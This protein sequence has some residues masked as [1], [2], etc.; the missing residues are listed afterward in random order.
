MKIFN[1]MTRKTEEFVPI[2][3]GK[4]G[5][6]VCGPTV[7]N[8][9]HIGNARP[10]CVFDTMRRY[11]MYRGYEVKYVQNFTDVDDKIIKKANEEGVES[12]EISERYI[13][14]FKT[15]TQGLNVL[16]PDISP[17]VTENMGIIIKIIKDLVDRG[18]AYQSG[19]DVYFETSKFADYGKLSHQ[20]LDELMAGAR[21]NVNEQKKSPMDFAV[22]KGAKE[23]EP[24]WN[25]PWGKGRPG[26]H[27]ECSAMSKNYIGNTLD[28]HGGGQDLIFPHHEN[29]IAQSECAT[30]EILANYWLHNGH[31]NVDNKKMSKS[32]GNFFT[33]RDVAGQYGYE[34][35]RL[36]LLQTSYRAPMNYTSEVIESCVAS[37]DRMYTARETIEAAICAA[38]D[39][40]VSQEAKN[41]IKTRKQRFIEV[42]DNDL[43]T[44]D[45]LSV[46]FEL[47]RDMNIMSNDK[48]VSK[49]QLTEV[50][51]LFDELT[52]VLGLM[53]KKEERVQIPDEIIELAEK[54]KKAR[55][56]KNFALAD[57][58]RDE[59]L[60]KGY[61]IEET[62]QGTKI[63]KKR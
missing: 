52:G 63:S 13:K 54:R 40:E 48:E 42:M 21:I 45:A 33:V 28:I 3:E 32:K 29:E 60:E 20:P 47:V 26:W 37:L 6:Y 23:G 18:Y 31:I 17:K 44:A 50:L 5:M 36:M 24:F 35:I 46:I 62:R 14:E 38:S 9:I 12:I 7:Y 1:T 16:E 58:I 51:S 19:N 56:E 22:W 55:T 8:L 25:S 10:L 49:Q 34:A 43:N 27:I 61:M 59:I 41:M 4:V 39:G 2:Q 15:D 57:E 11:L 53:Y 30:G